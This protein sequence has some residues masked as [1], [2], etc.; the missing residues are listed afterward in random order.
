MTKQNCDI[1]KPYERYEILIAGFGGQGVV[2]IGRI[3]GMAF[4]IFEGIN[5]I[6]TQSYGPE[7]RGGACRSEVIVCSGEINYPYVRRAHLL[8]SLSQL[9]LDKYGNSLRSEGI[10]VIDPDSVSAENVPTDFQGALFKVPTMKISQTIGNI[11]FQNSVAL[12]AI[13]WIIQDMIKENSVKDALALSVPHQTLEGNYLA[14]EQGKMF[15][16]EIMTKIN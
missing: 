15:L 14:F 8:V 3:L 10:L 16:R 11:K 2:T 6:N 12:G 13:Y 7:S 9:A 5:S 4:S 1:E